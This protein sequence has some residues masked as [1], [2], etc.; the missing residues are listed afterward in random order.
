LQ[1]SIRREKKKLPTYALTV[2][3]NGPKVHR[4]IDSGS[5]AAGLGSGESPSG[6]LRLD[7]SLAKFCDEL[8]RNTDRCL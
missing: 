2:A 6:T 3:K 4:T 7:A 8:S 5:G 1:V